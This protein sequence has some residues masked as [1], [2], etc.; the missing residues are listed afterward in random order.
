M[1]KK[2]KNFEIFGKKKSSSEESF[3]PKMH[4]VKEYIKDERQDK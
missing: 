4:Q 3:T 2:K 1:K